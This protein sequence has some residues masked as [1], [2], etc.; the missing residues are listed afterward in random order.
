MP[1]NLIGPLRDLAHGERRAAARIAV[2][3]REHDPGDVERLVEMRR[4]AHRLL[5][6]R[7]IGHEQH[8]LRLKEIAQPLELL[9]QRLVDFL[10][11]RGIVNL[12]VALLLVAP[13]RA[14]PR[15][16]AS[17]SFSPGGG[18]K[19]GTPICR[20]S[21]ASCSIA[22]GRCKIARDQQRLPP[23][24]LQPVRELRRGGR[25]ARAI[26][27]HHEDARRLLEIQRRSV[28]AEQRRQLIVENLDDLLPGRRPSAAPPRPA[29]SP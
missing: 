8:L 9:H 6:G 23:L 18:V 21:V 26:Q 16:S 13:M 19:T 7:G 10:P 17:T 5:A 27:A 25:L 11:A 15:P 28:A 1:A 12:H 2:E 24:L 14:P 22:A 3:L 4:H 20:P 29:P